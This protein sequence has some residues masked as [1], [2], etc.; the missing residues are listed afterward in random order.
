[1]HLADKC[2]GRFLRPIMQYS[3]EWLEKYIFM[4]YDYTNTHI[5]LLHRAKYGIA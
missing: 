5:M 4:M 1:M 2:V 3:S